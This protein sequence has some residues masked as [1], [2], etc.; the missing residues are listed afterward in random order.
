MTLRQTSDFFGDS[1]PLR[2]AH[3]GF[4]YEPRPQQAA[5]ATAIAQALD[6]GRNLCVEAPTGVGKTFAYLVPALFH[7][8]ATE[9]P[10]IVS[11]HTISLQEQLIQHDVPFLEKLLKRP[12]NAVVAKGRSNYLCLR[13]L[14]GI[15]DLE[16]DLLPG[17]EAFDDVA[18]LIDWAEK[19]QTGDHADMAEPIAPALW[20]AVASERGNC[21][22]NACPFFRNCFLMKARRKVAQA[23][24]IIANHALFFSALALDSTRA[25]GDAPPR[26]GTP[27]RL[28]PE[29]AA[30][31]IDEA[32]TIEDNAA[33]HLALK[34]E[35]LTL[36]R[37]LNRLCREDRQH[38]VLVSCNAH[39]A[40]DAVDLARRKA[41]QFFTH[42]VQWLTPLNRNPL[43]YTVPGHIPDFLEDALR[44]VESRLETLI[45]DL[46]DDEDEAALKAELNGLRQGIAEQR[47][48]MTAFFNM[49]LPDYVYWMELSGEAM[50]DLAFLS[51]PVN[52]A[53]ILNE[54][55]FS[56]PPVIL[57]SAT[58]A[59][60]GQLDFFLGR[61][62][63]WQA[64]KL[65]LDSP[66]DY[67]SQVR[68]YVAR[69]MPDPKSPDFLAESLSHI[70]RFLAQ[71]DGRAFVLFTS[72]RSLNDTAKLLAPFLK[73]HR[74]TLLKQGDGLSPRRM[75]QQFKRT[76]R[77][78]IFGT[79]SFWTGVDVPGDALANVIITKL[80]FAVPDHPL[81]EARA[82]RARAQGRNDFI[83]YSIPEAVLKFRQGFGRLIRTRTDSGIVVILDSRVANR[84][85][86]RIFLNSIPSCPI[87]YV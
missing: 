65:I 3:D 7:A 24:L 34:A 9:K 2:D 52:V 75:I 6:D 35:S 72:Y 58:L 1:S 11:T 43:R 23:Q 85:Y 19:T 50:Q 31:V 46:R 40:I 36:N 20:S 80:P 10:V 37:L 64:E 54:K 15:G 14:N 70:R 84:A 45:A 53:P 56:R 13:K 86:G 73:E 26:Q 82:E 25:H 12:I 16:R 17:A 87:E 8:D 27:E 4:R 71:T 39:D 66:F 79:S 51:V 32:H 42:I 61:I 78:V 5:M 57:T 29:P 55:L 48:A 49:T 47:A 62:G 69:S 83:E 38:G 21:L 76:P 22:N 59:V 77:A 41:R 68:L 60:N 81:V 18:K 33:D 28:L 44:T 74:M 67:Q 30:V 63:A